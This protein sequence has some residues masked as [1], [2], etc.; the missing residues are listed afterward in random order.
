MDLPGAW[1]NQCG[2]SEGSYSHPDSPPVAGARCFLQPMCE[3]C[4]VA[5]TSK[6][7]LREVRHV[8]GDARAG[9]RALG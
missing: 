6:G 2:T 4:V 1:P 9:K 8:P 5:Q 3:G 7:P